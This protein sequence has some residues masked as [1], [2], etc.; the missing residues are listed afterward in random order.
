MLKG[1]CI[2]T[3]LL[4]GIV[5]VIKAGKVVYAVNAGGESHVGSSNIKYL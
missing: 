4:S 2:I 3:L 5:D 1:V